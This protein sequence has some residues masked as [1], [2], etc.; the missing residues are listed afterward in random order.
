MRSSAIAHP[1]PTSN[2]LLYWIARVWF[3]VFGWETEGEPPQAARAVIIAAPHTSNWDMPH[4]MAAAWIFRMKIS[5]MG[6]HSL[7]KPPLGWILKPLGG[8]SVDRRAPQGAVKAIA[9]SFERD[10]RLFLAVPPSGTRQ[11]RDKW[12]SGFYWIATEAHVP[13][14]AGYLDFS[15][16]R[17]CLGYMFEPTGDVR[18]D[19]DRLRE[20]YAPIKGKFPEL[21]STIFIKEENRITVKD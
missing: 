9:S 15:R 1:G 19:M 8:V 14:V 17:A 3:W 18:A 16:K 13:I 12:K 7:F 2:I 21:Q 20:F 6:K 4:M 5:W 11:R 10:D